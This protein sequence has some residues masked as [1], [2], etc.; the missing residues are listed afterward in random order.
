MPALLA[1]MEKTEEIMVQRTAL[2]AVMEIVRAHRDALPVVA[3]A[4]AKLWD[5]MDPATRLVLVSALPQLGETGDKLLKDGLADPDY[6]LRMECL[7][8]LP[9][10][11]GKEVMLLP[12]LD[13]ILQ[14]A[15]PKVRQD[16]VVALQKFAAAGFDV[17]V[18]RYPVED[19]AVVKSRIVM[20]LRGLKKTNPAKTLEIMLDAAT[21]D[22]AHLRSTAVDSLPLF[23]DQPEAMERVHKALL[24]S[25]SVVRLT[26]LRRLLDVPAAHEKALATV[27]KSQD[28]TLRRTLAQELQRQPRVKD[29]AA[30]KLAVAVLAD[31]AADRKAPSLDREDAIKALGKIGPGAIAAVPVLR[32]LDKETDPFLIGSVRYS[33]QQIEGKKP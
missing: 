32:E 22:N 16:A 29:P 31:L 25:E 17:L 19:D 10:R 9:A 6:A 5:R 26:A 8:Y 24:D 1:L 12:I 3:T 21:S 4:V 27:Q 13:D 11:L 2:V 20:V 7:K 18:K 14:K 30:V 15:P 23:A 28:A 33:L